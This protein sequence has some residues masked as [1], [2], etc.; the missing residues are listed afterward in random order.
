MR[1]ILPILFLIFLLTAHYKGSAQISLMYNDQGELKADTNFR[2]IDKSVFPVLIGSRSTF[3]Y[4]ILTRLNIPAIM[5]D[6]GFGGI[7]I[8][9]VNIQ[10]DSIITEAYN[11]SSIRFVSKEDPMWGHKEMLADL[12]FLNQKSFRLGG[13]S[14]DI[15]TYNFH[16]PIN[17]QVI[18]SNYNKIEKYFEEGVFVF[19]A[20]LQMVTQPQY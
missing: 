3:Q 10:R 20:Y 13:E 1:K 8:I 12:E 14:A 2:L 11:I 5:L 6:A 7:V 17:I 18:E 4:L 15:E 16:I 9:D 19:K